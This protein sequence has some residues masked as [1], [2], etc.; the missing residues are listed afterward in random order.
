MTADFLTEFL[1]TILHEQGVENH[2]QIAQRAAADLRKAKI[3]DQR[4]L[5]TIALHRK[6]DELRAKGIPSS[7]IAKRFNLTRQT[8]SQIVRVQFV[9]RKA[10]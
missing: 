3:V 6:I 10:G 5:D 1:A 7:E 9:A 4:H 2:I 8:V